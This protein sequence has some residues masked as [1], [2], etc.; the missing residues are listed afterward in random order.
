MVCLQIIYPINNTIPNPYQCDSIRCK[1]V[2]EASIGLRVSQRNTLILIF[3]CPFR[4]AKQPHWTCTSFD[5]NGFSLFAEARKRNRNANHNILTA[6]KIAPQIACYY[7]CCLMSHISSTILLLVEQ[8]SGR[9]FD[10][11]TS[12]SHD[13]VQQL[14]GLIARRQ[15]CF[16]QGA[17]WRFLSRLDRLDEQWPKAWYT[18]RHGHLLTAVEPI[19]KNSCKCVNM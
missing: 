10:H 4:N 12:G 13:M 1:R 3:V 8:V 18:I 7:E 2:S 16:S 11:L 5:F 15:G 6:G 17:Q 9:P 19:Q 14:R